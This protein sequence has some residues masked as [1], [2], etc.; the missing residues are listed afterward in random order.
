VGNTYGA[1]GQ[2]HL[3]LGHTDQAVAFLRKARTEMLGFWLHHGV[4]AG[5]LRLKGDIDE[6]R[7]EIGE[8]LKLKPE[9]NSVARWRAI[10]ATMGG[11]DPR[12]QALMEKT[13]YAGVR[14]AGFPDE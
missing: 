9:V 3:F 5:A 12:N 4:L 8:M 6:A 11:G 7:A 2:G 10:R 13:V 1:L 14:R